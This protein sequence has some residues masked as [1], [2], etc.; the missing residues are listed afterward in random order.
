MRKDLDL[1]VEANIIVYV[2]CSTEFRELVVGHLDFISHEVR[3]TK[4]EFGMI[5]GEYKKKWN[6]ENEKMDISIIKS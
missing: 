2:A 5:K 4:I 1:D 3:A 6:I